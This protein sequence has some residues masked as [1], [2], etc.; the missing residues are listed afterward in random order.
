MK[1]E[2]NRRFDQIKKQTNAGVFG[3]DAQSLLKDFQKIDQGSVEVFFKTINYYFSK[4]INPLFKP[5]A[6]SLIKIILSLFLK[7]NNSNPGLSEYFTLTFNQDIEGLPNSCIKDKYANMLEAGHAFKQSLNANKLVLWELSKNYFLSYNE[8]M[9]HLIGI[10]LI[11]LQYSIKNKYKLNTL[12]NAY[13]NKISE[14]N[15]L[16]PKPE[17]YNT[18]LELLNSDIRNAIAHQSIW[19]N[20][21]SNNVIYKTNKEKEEKINITDFIMLNAKASYLAEAYLV[22]LSTIGVFYFGSMMDRTK[23]P[24]ELFL[25]I[26]EI[27]K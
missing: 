20:E 16:T 6:I 5:Y 13:G 19:F 1:K 10:I 23:F 17:Y 14:L 11:N 3:K 21:E 22:A 18:L 8:F 25:I 2:D 4:D 26:M 7:N 9:N 12:N 15:K 24:K 27:N